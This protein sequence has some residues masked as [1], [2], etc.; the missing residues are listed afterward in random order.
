MESSF[1]FSVF[2]GFFLNKLT[3]LKTEVL[4]C[5]KAKYKRGSLWLPWPYLSRP[6]QEEEYVSLVLRTCG[7]QLRH[8]IL[9]RWPLRRTHH[10][11]TA[12]GAG[13][14]VALGR[15]GVFHAQRK[16]AR[17]AFRLVSWKEA[18][19]RGASA[20]SAPAAAASDRQRSPAA[21]KLQTTA[22]VGHGRGGDEGQRVNSSCNMQHIFVGWIN[23]LAISK[24]P[25]RERGVWVQNEPAYVGVEE[26]RAGN[27]RDN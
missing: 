2:L 21:G 7:P 5:R 22:L 24:T 16:A 14:G 4:P 11:E 23:T 3:T 9:V 19:R 10:S 20:G 17:F 26:K 25:A 15:S 6:G 18:A 1:A 27:A 12:P 13:F 8:L